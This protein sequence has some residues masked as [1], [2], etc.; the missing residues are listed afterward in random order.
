MC[1][2][3]NA[4]QPFFSIKEEVQRISLR[5]AA[6]QRERETVNEWSIKERSAVRTVTMPFKVPDARVVPNGM[7]PMNH[8]CSWAIK[9]VPPSGLPISMACRTDKLTLRDP[10]RPH[11]D[12]F[13]KTSAQMLITLSSAFVLP[14]SSIAPLPKRPRGTNK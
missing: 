1:L 14:S 9:A 2:L 13:W 3:Q 11:G 4:F 8:G 5:M 12:S 6:Q 10:I 7:Q